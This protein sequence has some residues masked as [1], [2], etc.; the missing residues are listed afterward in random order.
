LRV[1]PLA[2]PLSSAGLSL[3]FFP[4]DFRGVLALPDLPVDVPAGLARLR[5]PVDFVS[6]PAPTVDA[7]P[8]ALVLSCVVGALVA[9]LLA[10]P[11][12]AGLDLRLAFALLCVAGVF[13]GVVALALALPDFEGV[14]LVEVV[15]LG[16]AVPTAVALP[17]ATLDALLDATLDASLGEGAVLRVVV[18]ATGAL[19]APL[20]AGPV[21]G[22]V[23]RDTPALTGLALAGLDLLLAVAL[24]CVAGVF[25]GVVALA[26]ALPDVAGIWPDATLDASLGV[27]LTEGVVLRTA[28][29]AAG[30]LAAPVLAGPASAELPL[31]APAL[32]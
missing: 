6:L 10:G 26:L 2:S 8:A 18:L 1:V 5:V 25:F 30:A 24:L 17:D 13:F 28:V 27:W 32:P 3:T 31:A 19:A 16:V 15:V 7:L 4:L 14:L 29:P 11:V 21:L 20:F 12:L 22:V 9:P 23:V